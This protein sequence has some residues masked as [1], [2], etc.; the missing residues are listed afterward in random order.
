MKSSRFNVMSALAF[1]WTLLH[2]EVGMALCYEWKG[3]QECIPD[4]PA[5]A[6][7]ETSTPLPMQP[8]YVITPPSKGGVNIEVPDFETRSINGR[9][10]GIIK[11]DAIVIPPSKVIER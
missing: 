2:P 1:A 7:P 10:A 4:E 6:T 9:P 11:Q 8:P 5:P 3:G